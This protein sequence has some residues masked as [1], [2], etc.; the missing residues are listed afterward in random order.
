MELF[1]RILVRLLAPSMQ[2]EL[3]FTNE[4]K[5]LP[6]VRACLHQALSQL[7]VEADT[8]AALGDLA[9]AAVRDAVEHAYPQGEEGSIKLTFRRRRSKLEILV[10]DFGMPQDIATLERRFHEPGAFDG[11]VVDQVHW[12]SFGPDGKEF[13]IVKWLNTE[14]ESQSIGQEDRRSLGD[15]VPQAPQQEYSI[16]RMIDTQAVQVSQLMYRA[17]G[18]TYFNEDVYYPER[19]ATQNADDKVLS[20]IARSKVA[21]LSG[22]TPWNSTRTVPLPKV[23]RPSYIRPIEVEGSSIA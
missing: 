2:F 10:R 12:R 5:T 21:T 4:P 9:L 1:V 22:I 18:N 13:Q 11:K 16:R 7:P 20:F 3:E 6:V 23:G 15:D 17:Y 19:L 14:D 8:A